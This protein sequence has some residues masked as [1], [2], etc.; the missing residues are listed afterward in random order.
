MKPKVL[1]TDSLFIFPEH[2]QQLKDA[3]Y[4]VVRLD[5]PDASED[6]L[7][8]AVQ[9]KVGYILGGIE[10][11]TDKVIAAAND[12][13]A[14][15]VTATGYQ[16]FIPGWQKAT[17]K[18]I[19]IANVPDGPTQAVAEWSLAAALAM[20]RGLFDLS[21]PNGKTFLTTSGLADQTLGIIALGRIGGRIAE[22]TQSFRP[23]ATLYYS[24]HRHKDKESSLGLQYRELDQLVQE[25]DIIFLCVPDS[26]GHSFFSAEYIAKMKKNALLVSFMHSSIIDVDALHNAL[27]AGKIRA[28][29]DYPMDDR[30]HKFP[31]S[32]FYSF[33]GSNAFNTNHSLQLMSDG[34][35]QSLINLLAN[36]E[37]EHRV[38]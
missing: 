25:S 26:A 16:Y 37:D 33:K 15:A 3:G 5:K 30:F 21:S 35:T 27:A 19:A 13:K 36:G 11:V 1:V 32:T 28:I 4:E 2:E 23:A 22:L 7:C 18:G 10:K 14:I 12:L 17:E 9:G 29:S 8:E 20:N 6:E 31:Q 24:T 38:N 34:A